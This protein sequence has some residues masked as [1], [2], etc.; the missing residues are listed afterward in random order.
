MTLKRELA[1]CRMKK[2]KFKHFDEK[3]AKPISFLL[4]GNVPPKG[5]AHFK[6]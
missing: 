6:K 1:K 2:K 3:S 5:S 4:L